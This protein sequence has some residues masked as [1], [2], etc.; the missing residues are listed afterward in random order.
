MARTV[1]VE[2]SYALV[3]DLYQQITGQKAVTA[4]DLST[5]SAVATGIMK[6]TPNQIY[7]GLTEMLAKLQI[8][9]RPYNAP[10]SLNFADGDQ[11]GA[12]VFKVSY[13][14]NGEAEAN[15]EWAIKD[16]DTIGT[17]RVKLPK[18]YEADIWGSNT[19]GAHVTITWDQIKTALRG[20]SDLSRFFS[21]LMTN[22]ENQMEQQREA[23]C[24]ANILNLIGGIYSMKDSVDE[25]VGYMKGS[26]VHLLT[27]YK[28]KFGK[29]YK[30][31]AELMAVPA[32]YNQFI[33]YVFARMNYLV[34]KMGNRDKYYHMNPVKDPKV[35]GTSG[36]IMRHSSPDNLRAYLN[37][38]YLSDVQTQVLTDVWNLEYLKMI[39]H[40]EVLY[41]QGIDNPT[42][43]KV[44]PKMMG[45]DGNTVEPGAQT[46]N[47]LFGVLFDKDSCGVSTIESDSGDTPYDVERHAF[48]RYWSKN[49]KSWNDFTEKAVILLMD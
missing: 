18:V 8:Q 15:P 35:A 17:H 28:T 31:M 12:H 13:L 40:E 33:K 25:D 41:W 22:I 44:S 34:K 48:N 27:E 10:F 30:T 24:R 7:K 21:G 45:K 19:W 47:N 37:Y 9:V 23:A 16:G 11:Y 38:E 43:V 3:N 6:H 42:S 20:P 5:F 4:V 36:I 29:Q 26:T 14:D 2:Q 32:D 49:V 46:I 1:T 39:P